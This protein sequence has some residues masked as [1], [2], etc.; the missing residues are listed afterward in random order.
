M[1]TIAVLKRG[2]PIQAHVADVWIT[3]DVIFACGGYNHQTFVLAST[4]GTTFTRTNQPGT[5]GIRRFDDQTFIVGNASERTQ[6]RKLVGPKKP[7]KRT[8]KKRP[9]AK[10]KVKTTT[11]KRKKTTR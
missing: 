3:D 6:M 2:L 9:T 10:K 7:K 8:M 11:T 1:S 4:D 5:S